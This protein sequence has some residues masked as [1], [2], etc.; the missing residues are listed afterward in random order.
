MNQ[1]EALTKVRALL[2]R[3]ADDWTGRASPEPPWP[4]PSPEVAPLK[5]RRDSYR[6]GYAAGIRA[7]LADFDARNMLREIMQSVADPSADVRADIA[8]RV[9]RFE[10]RLA[11]ED[12]RAAIVETHAVLDK[13]GVPKGHG[14]VCDDPDCRSKLAHRVRCLVNSRDA[15][16]R[17]EET[18][19][20][21]ARSAELTVEQLMQA[22]GIAESTGGRM[23]AW[24]T[25]PYL[26][27]TLERLAQD[28]QWG[29]A[30]VD[31]SR[32]FDDWMR[33]IRYQI[34]QAIGHHAIRATTRGR[35][36]KIAALAIAAIESID[37]RMARA[38]QSHLKGPL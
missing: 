4:T 25:R 7:L 23:H 37:R 32:S 17:L 3:F 1:N 31:D 30:T 8:G 11:F 5:V 19:T 18:L 16:Y 27:V 15:L 2:R 33:F 20:E 21:R 38:D 22:L 9:E 26:D 28:R 6:E 34:S 13:A 14:A 10:Q 35:L 24:V 36:V 12:A 29:G